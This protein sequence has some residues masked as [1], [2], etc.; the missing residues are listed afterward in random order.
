VQRSR[1]RALVL[2]SQMAAVIHDAPEATAETAGIESPSIARLEERYIKLLEEKIE[3]LE[4]EATQVQ[5]QAAPDKEDSHDLPSSK[6]EDVKK[7]QD[8]DTKAPQDKK[9]DEK[10]T[11]ESEKIEGKDQEKAKTRKSKIRYVHRK[12]TGF[13]HDE[14]EVEQW[15]NTK[16]SEAEAEDAPT[17]TW[18]RT[19]PA[20]DTSAMKQEL[21]IESKVLKDA[22]NE[23]LG[24]TDEISFDTS[25]VAIQAPYPILY[26]NED[27]LR[28]Y[29]DNEANAA[30]KPDIDTRLAALQQ[31]QKSLRKD[32]DAYKNNG[33]ITFDLL[34][35]LF[36]PGC[37]VVQNIMGEP[38]QFVVSHILH[39]ENDED[40]WHMFVAGID[41][42]GEAFL[43]VRMT[44][45]IKQFSGSKPIFDLPVHPTEYWRDLKGMIRVMRLKA[46]TL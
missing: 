28:K 6:R 26:H 14:E 3:R 23:V 35:A 18:R 34:W 1:G 5:A 10:Q 41:F 40:R 9:V 29:A 15:D 25:E 8:G 11:K 30:A 33:A 7:N 12:K 43:P 13:C 32:I 42:D 31:E 21:I 45:T 24:K 4:R 2:V 36:Y 27:K 16:S 20:N 22:L 17:I 19:Q 37:R 39:Y 38:Q 44:V 46:S